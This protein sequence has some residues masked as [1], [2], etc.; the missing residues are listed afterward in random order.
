MVKWLLL[1]LALVVLVGIVAAGPTTAEYLMS[2]ACASCSAERI[3]TDVTNETTWDFGTA[4]QAKVVKFGFNRP[5]VIASYLGF[6]GFG[7]PYDGYGMLWL[8]APGVNTISSSAGGYDEV[9]GRGWAC[10]DEMSGTPGTEGSHAQVENT[11]YPGRSAYFSTYLTIQ[12]DDDTRNFFGFG[13]ADMSTDDLTGHLAWFRWNG[14]VDTTFKCITNDNSGG[15]TISD[16]GVTAPDLN[17]WHWYEIRET[18]GTNWKFYIDGTLV[19][20]NNANLPTGGM[21]IVSGMRSLTGG[22]VGK[23][24]GQGPLYAEQTLP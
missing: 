15:G 19:C 4:S 11:I 16:S 20:T 22:A 21:K 6:C 1:L 14:Q 8:G 9:N 3:G 10:T 2:S 24:T 5:N 7:S 18:N 23:Q 17:V 12:S 13:P